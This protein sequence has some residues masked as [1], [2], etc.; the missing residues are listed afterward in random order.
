LTLAVCAG[1]SSGIGSPTLRIG[2]DG[3]R[4]AEVKSAADLAGFEIDLAKALCTRSRITCELLPEDAPRLVPA[5]LERKYDA[6][7]AGLSITPERQ[8]VIGFTRPY[9][10]VSH[11]FAVMDS[12]R[13]AGLPGDGK[14]LSL[15][16]NPEDSRSHIA[17]LRNALSGRIIGAAAGTPDLLFLRK[18]FGGVATIREYA[19]AELQYDDLAAGHIDAVMD[20]IIGIGAATSQPAYRRLVSTGPRFSE[21]EILGFGI[22]VG[23]RKADDELRD[24]F[25]RAA[26]EMISDGSLRQLSL[27][28]FN[29]DITPH[30]CACKPF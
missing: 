25:D 7:I 27:K 9:A 30:R 11:G 4:S 19:T 6:I 28:W 12:G 18:H 14:S 24:M 10:T 15:S 20:S 16:A 26:D 3:H 29:L 2:T 23:V 13:L 17:A 22:A 1:A 5:L 8:Q 21:D